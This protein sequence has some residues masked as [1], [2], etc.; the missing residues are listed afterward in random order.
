MHISKIIVNNFRLLKD[1]MLDLEEQSDKNLSVMIGRNNSGKTSFLMILDKF[2]KNSSSFNI[3][4]F[5]VSIRKNIFEINKDTDIYEISIKLIIEI[6][7]SSEDNLENLSDFILDLNPFKNKVHILFECTIDKDELLKEIKSVESKNCNRFIK[8]NISNYLVTKIYSFDN[9]EN[10]KSENRKKL[11]EKDSKAIENLINYQVIHAKRNVS[12]S[13]SGE[14][15]KKV[16][17]NLTTKYYNKKMEN[18]LSS[19][20]LDIINSELLKMDEKL[21]EKYKDFF[22]DFLNKSKDFLAMTELR[23]ISDLESKGIISNH[24]KIVYGKEDEA[25]PEYLNGLGYMNILYLL[26][27]LEIKKEFLIEGKKDINLLFIEEPEAHTHPQMQTIF[28]KKIKSLLE[29]IPSLQTFITT[30]SACIVKNSDFKDIRY[31]YND[32]KQNIV[33]KN[34]YTELKKKYEKEEDEFKFLNQYLSIASAELFFAEKI[35]FIEGLTEKLFLPYFIKEYD[36]INSDEVSISSQNIS[37]IE[38]GANAKAFRYFIEFLGIKALIITDIDTTKKVEKLNERTGKSKINYPACPVKEGTHTSNATIRYFYDSPDFNQEEE[39]KRWFEK[40]K[41][42]SLHN[43]ESKIKLSFQIEEN[44][45]QGR[46]FE[47]AFINVNR[48]T[49][50][51][52]ISEINGVKK[53]TERSLNEIADVDVLTKRI[54][55]KK[56]DF[57]SS[58]L[59]LALAKDVQWKTPSYIEEGL[60]WIVK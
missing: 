45:Y 39:W 37:I 17:S 19:K 35:I 56:S 26:L 49:L 60:K 21:E 51:A 52:H 23:V 43:E 2:L 31:F 58:L 57:A 27:Q 10:L 1:S 46:S 42:N 44:R 14:N 40:L 34:F 33:I 11:I 18:Q 7:Y 48:E 15:S 50:K 20:E 38:V 12:S 22:S 5:P 47:E 36:K 16:L 29:D 55:D 25:L 32:S 9:Y 3:Y 59:W 41:T 54:L 24:S 4:D 13:E 6:S 30:H 8:K 28:I 53:E